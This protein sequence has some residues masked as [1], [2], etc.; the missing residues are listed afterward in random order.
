MMVRAGAIL[1]YWQEALIACGLDNPTSAGSL[2]LQTPRK[3]PV[4]AASQPALSPYREIAG[5]H[6]GPVPAIPNT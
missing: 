6:C 1:R 3:I 4:N 5:G 2:F